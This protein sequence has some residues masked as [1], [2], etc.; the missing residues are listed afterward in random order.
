[1]Y[2][3]LDL[4]LFAGEKTEKATPLKKR[5]A[6]KKGQVAKS[7]DLTNAIVLLASFS[8]LLIMGEQTVTRLVNLFRNGFSNLLLVELTEESTPILFFELLKE[9]I[10]I[11]VPF[12]LA[13][14][15]AAIAA[16]L[17]Q[18]GFLVSTEALK[19]DLKRLDPIKGAKKIF[20]LRSLVEFIKSILKVIVIGVITGLM[21]WNQRGIFA[22]FSQ[23]DLYN[24][25]T[26]LGSLMVKLGVIISAVYL[27]IGVGDFLYQRFD[28]GKQLRMSKHDIKDEYKKTEGDPLIKQRMKEKQQQA[29]RARMMAEVP[30]AQVLVTNPTHFAVAIAYEPGE[31][32]VP[33]VVAKGADFL[34]LKMREVAKEHDVVIM[35]NKTLARALYASVEAGQEIPE[36]L[37]KVVAEILAYVYRVKGTLNKQGGRKNEA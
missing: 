33:V 27:V 1:M 10:W 9:A 7:T 13:A 12:I 11:T 2:L 23:M 29:S 4:Q 8:M 16:L 32:S 6:R 35:E 15:I 18:V 28:H 25:V 22:Q 3:S 14:G 31:M 24:I 19:L 34:A 30:N 36:D 26:Y 17:S 37:F 20:S 21:I 5:E